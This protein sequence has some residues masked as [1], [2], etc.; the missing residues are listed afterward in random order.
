MKT[1]RDIGKEILEGLEEIKQW[2]QGK[3]KLKV[4]HI[5]FPTAEDVAPIRHELGLSQEAFAAFMNVSVAT[6]RNWEQGRR[7]PQ[8]PARSLLFIAQ[9]VPNAFLKAF[10]LIRKAA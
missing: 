8:G 10:K 9:N 7:E 6:L 2:Q 5:S 3:K 4:T 1:Q